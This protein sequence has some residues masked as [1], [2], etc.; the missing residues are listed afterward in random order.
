MKHS[1][2]KMLEKL[3]N[4]LDSR[5]KLSSAFFKS[6]V[7]PSYQKRCVHLINSVGTSQ[8]LQHYGI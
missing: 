7:Y 1:P 8:H 5:G 3:E 4:L 2:T 6:I